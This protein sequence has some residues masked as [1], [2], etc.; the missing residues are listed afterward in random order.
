MHVKVGSTWKDG[1]PWVKVGSTWKKAVAEWVKV[2]SVWKRVAYEI[3][4]VLLTSAMSK[5]GNKYFGYTY[6][7]KDPNKF[8]TT[9]PDWHLDRLTLFAHTDKR[10]RTPDRDPYVWLEF[11]LNLP[12]D[13]GGKE[14]VRLRDAIIANKASVIV[15]KSPTWFVELSGANCKKPTGTHSVQ[16]IPNS[17]A[18]L[19]NLL[20]NSGTD[21]VEVEVKFKD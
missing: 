6:S 12:G 1:I 2:G 11:K 4:H 3:T 9:E 20:K 5:S 15:R 10:N 18:E 16:L 19:T 17:R 14:A 13:A 7:S 8:T 21:T